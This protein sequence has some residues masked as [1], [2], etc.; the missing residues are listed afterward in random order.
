MLEIKLPREIFKSPFAMEPIVQSLLQGG[1]LSTWH[2]KHW[3]GNM[4]QVTSLEIASI[5]GTIHFYIRIHKKFK[6]LVSANIYAQYPGIEITEADDYTKLIHYHHKNKDVGIWGASYK[7]SKDWTPT[8]PKNG[9]SFSKKHKSEPEDKDDE[10]KM[11]ADFLPIKTYVD[12]GLD[13]DPKEEFKTDPIVPLLEFMGSVAK[14]EYVWYQILLQEEAVFAKK[15]TKTYV[16]E[17]THEYF[18]LKELA[19]D[20]VK[21]IRGSK[22]ILKGTPVFDD[23][24][25][26]KMKPEPTGEKDANGKPEMKDV[27]VTHQ[28]DTVTPSKEEMKLTQSE[29]DEIEA[30]EN[31][32]G[33]PLARVVIRL[34][35]LADNSKGKFNGGHVQNILSIMKPFNGINTFGF[36]PTSPYDYPWENFRGRREP[37]R[38]E[39]LFEE[40]VEREGFHPHTS[41]IKWLSKFEDNFFWNY[42]MK[43][44]KV[45][46]MIFET[47][48]K[49]FDHPHADR[50]SVLNT[51]EIATL[52]HFPG[53]VASVPALPRVDSTKGMA[54]SNLPQ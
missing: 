45:F 35:Y 1:G 3:Q 7:L 6:E 38:G 44:R 8:N 15:W 34:I 10:Y 52:Y 25:Y 31:K 22:I 40:Y 43:H 30:I 12:Y 33:K 47:I 18:T 27:Q 26:P 2:H 51:E 32:V 42:S 54:P 48:L 23:Y 46:R 50:V 49:P 37:W 20:R 24:G 13:K 16:N 21:Q 5:E 53:Q 28:K 9:L 19:K 14:G 17:V 36:I 4:P 41:D 39:E 11:Q 29:K